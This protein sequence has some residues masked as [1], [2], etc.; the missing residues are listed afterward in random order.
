MKFIVIKL[1]L[2]TFVLVVSSLTAQ[3]ENVSGDLPGDGAG[4]S[5]YALNRDIAVVSITN[6]LYR[7]DNGGINWREIA[8]EYSVIDVEMI[9]SLVIIA[10]AE[11]S[12]IKSTDGGDSWNTKFAGA[13]YT[14]FFDYLEM[15]NADEGIAVGDAPDNFSPMLVV[16]TSDGGETWVIKSNTPNG[17]W[18]RDTWKRICFVNGLTGWLIT[19]GVSDLMKT[20]DGGDTWFDTGCPVSGKYVVKFA[21]SLKG[22]VYGF[23]YN[24]PSYP[25]YFCATSDGGSSWNTLTGVIADWAED[26]EF[27]R[28]DTDKLLICTN[29]SLYY[30]SDFGE[31]WTD[32]TY[33]LHTD[34]A[35]VLRDLHFTEDGCCWLMGDGGRVFRNRD[36]NT[37]T[38]VKTKWENS[39]AQFSLNQNYPNPF[40]PATTISYSIPEN[41]HV[42][43][44]IY[45]SLGRE[46]MELQNDFLYAGIYNIQ[47]DASALSSGVYYYVLTAGNFSMTKKCLVMK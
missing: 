1:V 44:N 25:K 14:P 36:L 46:I 13:N 34:S 42:L 2:I 20:S 10:A 27:F 18:S 38:V 37:I 24:N 21:N 40:N 9:D 26:I 23:D 7:T 47:F 43:L 29:K 32:L 11:Q 28:D 4:F 15:F 12:I 35:K 17:Y 5:L 19:P 33:Q 30:S 31:S 3:W 8:A 45:D 22:I 16:S 6:Q 39:P 41:C